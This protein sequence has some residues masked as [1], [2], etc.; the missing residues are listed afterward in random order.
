MNAKARI[1]CRILTVLFLV[2]VLAACGGKPAAN[3]ADAVNS[4]AQSIGESVGNAAGNPRRLNLR[5]RRSQN[6]EYMTKTA[7]RSISKKSASKILI[8]C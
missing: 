8:I 4:G 7:L 2:A 5:C 3:S 1:I 6:R